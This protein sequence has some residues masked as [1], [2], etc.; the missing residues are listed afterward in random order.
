[1]NS[2][3]GG[4][5]RLGGYL[6]RIL[7]YI[8]NP[9]NP[10]CPTECFHPTVPSV[11]NVSDGSGS[12][13]DTAAAPA[14]SG[15]GGRDGEEKEVKGKQK[16]PSFWIPSLTPQAKATELKK[17]VSEYVWYVFMYVF[18]T[19]VHTYVHVSIQHT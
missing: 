14:P 11:S 4:G 8:R 12:S 17:P 3:W 1:M 5:V 19:V 16:L 6:H 18:S 10:A 15:A 13:R 2:T 9:S 7:L